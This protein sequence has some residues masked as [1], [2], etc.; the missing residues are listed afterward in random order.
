[1]LRKLFQ[2]FFGTENIEEMK[3]KGMLVPLSFSALFSFEMF[4]LVP[5]TQA[6]VGF[7]LHYRFSVMG[8]FLILWIGNLLVSTSILLFSDKS[9]SDPTLAEGFRG[10]FEASLRKSKIAGL[11]FGLCATLFLIFWEGAAAYLIFLRNMVANRLSQVIIF[12][13]VSGIQMAAWTKVYV[14]GYGL[15]TSIASFFH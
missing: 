3:R 13:A 10:L 6:L 1:M 7:L 5:V 4:V 8:V 14:Y 11:I 2:I 9:K 12:V 15:F